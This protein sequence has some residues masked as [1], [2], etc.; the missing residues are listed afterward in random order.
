LHW[1]HIDAVW[2]TQTASP[3]TGKRFSQHLARRAGGVTGLF[4]IPATIE[5]Y[6]G[7]GPF[8]AAATANYNY[9]QLHQQQIS[10]KVKP[11][12][13]QLQQ[14]PAAW[15]ANFCNNKLPQ[16]RYGGT[17]LPLRK[18]ASAQN[19]YSTKLPQHTTAAP[20]TSDPSG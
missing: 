8:R 6:A 18:T 12:D 16:N 20:A 19:C 7:G 14:Q 3:N 2:P 10:A 1:L 9:S 4:S 13:S 5:K 17:E 11:G 15:T